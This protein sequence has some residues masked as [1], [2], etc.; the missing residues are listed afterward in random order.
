MSRMSR[1]LSTTTAA[2]FL[3]AIIVGAGGQAST[4]LYVSTD[5]TSSY[6]STG[7]WDL[8]SA[9]VVPILP[10]LRIVDPEP[11]IVEPS[12]EPIEP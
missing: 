3:G 2:V 8:P 1:L 9:D 5:E 11:E 7:K 4:A 10:E 6:V 12:A